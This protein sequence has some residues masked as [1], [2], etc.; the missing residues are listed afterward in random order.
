MGMNAFV[1]GVAVSVAMLGV[2]KRLL[3]RPVGP[4]TDTGGAAIK[5]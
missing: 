2:T 5:R 4:T 1:L 3:A